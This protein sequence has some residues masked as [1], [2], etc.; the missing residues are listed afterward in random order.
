MEMELCVEKRRR[1]LRRRV[2][3]GEAQW[4][5]DQMRRA[6]NLAVEMADRSVPEAMEN[7]PSGTRCAVAR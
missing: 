1:E 7:V 2:P 5:F 3:M 4:W 6:A